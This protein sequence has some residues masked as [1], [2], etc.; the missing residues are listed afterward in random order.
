VKE[1]VLFARTTTIKAD[2][3]KM[4]AGIAHVRDHVIP[5][6]TAMEGC[7]GMSLLVNR[8]TG[9]SIATT[10]W[11]S[12]A[13]LQSSAPKVLSIRD[14]AEQILG[15]TTSTVDAWELAVV[16]RDH[17]TPN[18]ACARVTYLSGDPSTA[19]RAIDVY[20]MAVL[21]RIQQFDGFCSSSFM[22]NRETGR[23]VGTVTFETRQQLEAT[24]EASAGIREGATREMSAMVDDVIEMDLALAHL[25]VPEMA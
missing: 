23:A 18:G 1:L 21:P 17:A 5:A 25:H 10:A 12:E 4:D 6:V 9:L 15:A 13:A 19:D 2:P 16:H 7:V 11:E 14:S 8:E 22:V 24:R 3:D 20:R